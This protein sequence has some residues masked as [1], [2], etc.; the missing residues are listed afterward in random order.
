MGIVVFVVST[1]EGEHYRESYITSEKRSTARRK[2]Q[3]VVS[4]P[5]ADLKENGSSQNN[6]RGGQVGGKE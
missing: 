2:V 6:S 1:E 3:F 5:R 4:A